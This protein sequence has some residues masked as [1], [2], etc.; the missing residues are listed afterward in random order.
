M[1]REDFRAYLTQ[2]RNYSPHTIRAYL[3]DL[4]GFVNFLQNQEVEVSLEEVAYE[5]IRE[6][7]VHLVGLGIS[8]RAINRKLASLKAYYRFIQRLGIRQSNPLAY[9][10][11]LKAEINLRVPFSQ[12]EMSSALKPAGD[13]TDFNEVRNLLIIGL[14]YATGIRRA[15]LVGLELSAIQLE[16]RK[17][18]VLGKGNKE[19]M[20]PLLPWCIELIEDYLGLRSQ[21]AGADTVANLLIT[22][23][24]KPIYPGLVYRVVQ[25]SF[26]KITGKQTRSP[27]IIRH[28]F[29][30]HLLD[31]GADLMSI[32]ELLGHASLSST[33][34]YTHNSMAKLKRVHAMSHPRN[35]KK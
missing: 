11:P 3:D 9:H 5:D 4:A 24:G 1:Y 17:L 35:K 13:K 18:R 32:K 7:I 30:T 16:S 8:N 12:K 26:R 28:T 21:I 10:Q 27:H 25:D 14:L 31:K 33:Q 34:I 22:E 15:E 29:A 2:E 20:L 6:W 19:R 23:K